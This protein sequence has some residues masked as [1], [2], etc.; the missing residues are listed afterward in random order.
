MEIIQT[1]VLGLLTVLSALTMLQA[2]KG[3]GLSRRGR[4]RDEYAARAAAYAE[5]MGGAGEEK[6][7]HA[8]DC[9]R[10][11]DE[12]DNGRRDYSDKEARLSIEAHL[13]K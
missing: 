12:A 3:G 5:Q 8:L 6:L 9:F 2:R 4:R 13:G 1:V 7:R 10:A 11:L